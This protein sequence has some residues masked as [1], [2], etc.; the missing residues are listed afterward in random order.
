MKR[1][2]F[3]LTIL[4]TSIPAMAQDINKQLIDEKT[5]NAMLIGEVTREGMS[6]MGAWFKREY[7]AYQPQYEVI[8]EIKSLAADFPRVFIVMGTWCSDSRE[9]VPHFYKV[10]DAIGYPGSQVFVVGVNRE[11]KANTFCLDDFD[12]QLVPTF[13]FS[14]DGEETGRIVETPST[15]IEHDLLN[16]LLGPASIH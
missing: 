4:S 1:L 9:Q 11:K 7:D 5:G 6:E 8:A 12:I 16:I 10:M 13:I 14:R 15:S 2:I 3:V